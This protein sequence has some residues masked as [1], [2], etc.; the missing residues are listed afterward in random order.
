MEENNQN[1]DNHSAIVKQDSKKI[2][3]ISLFYFIV[4]FSFFLVLFC[5]SFYFIIYYVFFNGYSVND[6]RKDLFLSNYVYL[7]HSNENH[8]LK[9]K[10][11][12]EIKLLLNDNLFTTL[13]K[14]GFERENV[15]EVLAIMNKKVNLKDLKENQRFLID[16]SFRTTYQEV[17]AKKNEKLLPKKAELI[18]IRK[19]DKMSF[20]LP[21]GP[22]YTI[23][24]NNNNYILHIEKPKL[25]VKTHIISGTIQN[26]V[27]AD[28]LV[29]DINATTLYNVLNEYAFLID[30]QR[31]IRANDKFTFVLE[32]TRDGDG[33]FVEEK[34][35]Y[36]NLNLSNRN[37]EIFNFNGKFYDREGKS[38]Q[39]NLLKTPVDG[40]RI[41]SGFNPKRKHPIL[42]YTRAH[43]GID[44]AVPMGTPIYSAGDGV[45]SEI[46]LD[47]KAYGKFVTIRHNRE[48]STRY[49]HM[50]RIGKLKIGQRVKQRQVIGYVGMTGLATGP[51]LHYEVIRYG[52]HI[53]PKNVK[54]V[55]TK[56]LDKNKLQEL[57]ILV[58]NIDKM[59]EN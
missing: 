57:K 13:I 17:S 41:S 52:K 16:Y 33:D 37:Y 19:V 54:A 26:S 34:V 14:N 25:I 11:N 55:E 8:T 32:T 48:Y 2:T 42:G 44:L 45:V 46:Q 58:Q 20:K 3:K 22:K 30:F 21:K 9:G 36:S 4:S 5:A 27:F 12:I 28:A 35:L 18:E 23:E 51:H 40:A 1:L 6:H 31:D 53:N 49:A 24:K 10:G 43:T 50:S 47:H 56:K 59:L 7:K 39:K 38:I 29:S 15:N